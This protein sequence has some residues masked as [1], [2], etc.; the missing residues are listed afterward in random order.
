M[1][2]NAI[3]HSGDNMKTIKPIFLIAFAA[4][5]SEFASLPAHADDA[6]CKPV[7][8]AIAKQARTP[9]HETG[10]VNGKPFEKIYTTTTLYIGN[11]GRW[12]KT[13]AT[14]KDVLDAQR[15]TGSSLSDCK[16]MRTETIDGQRAT[17][18]AA[19]TQ[20]TMPAGSGDAQIWIGASG[21]TLKTVSDA[22]VEGHKAHTDVR[23]TYDN[24]QAPAA[25]Q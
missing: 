5:A 11:N 16:V 15:E 7:S 21:L 14:P 3:T 22:Q 13:P 8:D 1:T 18:Y 12:L 17:V 19:H 4:L 10:T 2:R 24:V 23:L 25:A 9:Y 6:S 20:T